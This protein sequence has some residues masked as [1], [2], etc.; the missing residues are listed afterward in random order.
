MGDATGSA[1][2]TGT[3]DA[4]RLRPG[5]AVT[6]LRNGLHLRGR[7]GSVTLEGS[8]ALPTLWR[9]LEEPLRTGD[10]TEL[11]RRA[12]PGSS[13]RK[14]LDTLI[15]QLRAHDLLVEAP[16]GPVPHWVAATAERPAEAASAIAAARA[17]VLADAAA[18]PLAEAAGRALSQGGASVSY[19]VGTPPHEG[20]VLLCAGEGEE[21]WAVAA[22]VC[23]GSGYVTAPGSAAQVRAD[24]AA[25]AARLVPAVPASS[26]SPSSAS[27]STSAAFVS[28]LAGSA[29]HR[30]LCAVGG[31]PDPASE[32]DDQRLLPGLPAVLVADGRPLRADYRTWLGPDR[33]DADRR[34]ALAPPGTLAEALVRV[35]ALGDERAGVLPAPL[36]GGLRQLPVPLAT[37]E[38]PGGTVLAGAPR[39]DLAR[40]DAFCR[41]AEVRLGGA[42]RAVGA[43]PSHAWG[44][45]LRRAA[46]GTTA[47]AP[48]AAPLPAAHWSEHPQARHWWTSLTERQGVRARLEVF[49]AHPDEDVHHAVV[50]RHPAEGGPERDLGQVLGRAVEA[51]PGDAAAFAALSAVAAVSAAGEEPNVRYFCGSDGSAAALAAVNARTAAWEDSGWT[52]GWLSEV[53]RREPALH[54]ALHRLTGLRAEESAVAEE[55]AMADETSVAGERELAARLRA[56]GF[57]VLTAEEGER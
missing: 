47:P 53:A 25:L 28:L 52:T 48:G 21:Q 20:A 12:E 6:L 4:W 42:C 56:F 37:C 23:G 18:S 44:R 16:V 9:L 46:A 35:A 55:T 10:A 49:R 5:V 36:P 32:G 27:P 2:A 7:R 34:V 38:L 31:L 13:V 45:A 29:A 40:L 50:C 11:L 54:T 26:A 14:A 43:N 33:L 3:A 1:H 15:A 8:T 17:R 51:T 22:G 19:A 30:L 39:L 41:A 57:T 24:A